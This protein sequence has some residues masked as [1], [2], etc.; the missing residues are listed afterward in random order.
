MIGTLTSP[1]EFV[2]TTC[3]IIDD[4]DWEPLPASVFMDKTFGSFGGHELPVHFLE[5]ND[6]LFILDDTESLIVEPTPIR[7]SLDAMS[8]LL[9]PISPESFDEIFEA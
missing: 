8:Q 7:E 9:E 2:S 5:P 3:K 6:S 1:M 4:D